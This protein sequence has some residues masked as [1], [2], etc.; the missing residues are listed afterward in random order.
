[1]Q[2]GELLTRVFRDD[3]RDLSR[4]Q[5]GCLGAVAD[6]VRAGIAAEAGPLQGA[7]AAVLVRFSGQPDL[8]KRHAPLGEGAGLVA[9]DHT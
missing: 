4:L 3:A 8:R 6:A 1:M 5:Q 2:P 7:A 9:A